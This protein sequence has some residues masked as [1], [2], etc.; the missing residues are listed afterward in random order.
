[1]NEAMKK[2]KKQCKSK[3]ITFYKCDADILELANRIN[4]QEYVK[5]CLRVQLAFEKACEKA[6]EKAHEE[7]REA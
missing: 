2:Y 4:F 1:M 5:T 7:T 6:C 3:L